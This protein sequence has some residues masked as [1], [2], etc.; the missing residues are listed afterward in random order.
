MQY[1]EKQYRLKQYRLKQ[2]EESEKYR[3]GEIA[4]H[5]EEIKQ[6]QPGWC[7]GEGGTFSPEGIDW[8][9]Q[10]FKENYPASTLHPEMFP[11]V[12]GHVLMDWRLEPWRPTLQIN[13]LTKRGLWFSLLS[14]DEPRWKN[15]D[16]STEAAWGWLVRQIQW[17]V[18]R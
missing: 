15:L 18:A 10:A 12:G 7:S 8:L 11:T 6:L 2:Q 3:L 1:L 14:V 5:L 16:L 13:V 4:R 17:M 9:F